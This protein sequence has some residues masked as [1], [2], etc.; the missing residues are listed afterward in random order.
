[1]FL[2]AQRY[3]WCFREKTQLKDGDHL[4]DQQTRQK[5]RKRPQKRECMEF[6]A[7]QLSES[8]RGLNLV[9]LHLF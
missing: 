7:N 9:V 6:F 2:V 1:M 4:L 3:L 8:P 5:P